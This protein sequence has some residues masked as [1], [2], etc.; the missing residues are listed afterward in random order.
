MQNDPARSTVAPYSLRGM[1]WPTVS[2][3][4][5]W[6]EVELGSRLP[7]RLVFVADEVLPRLARQGDLYAPML[8]AKQ[9]LPG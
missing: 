4:V 7:D 8:D 3:P 5:S 6:D 1:P 2:M 9:C